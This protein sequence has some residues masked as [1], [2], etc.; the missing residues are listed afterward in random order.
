MIVTHHH[1]LVFTT[2]TCRTITEAIAPQDFVHQF[3]FSTSME[4]NNFLFLCKTA[5]HRGADEESSIDTGFIKLSSV[6]LMVE[7]PA[8]MTAKDLLCHK[9]DQYL[10]PVIL[11]PEVFNQITDF[12]RK[13]T[14]F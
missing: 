12:F 14:V 6:L 1:G 2:L 7:L 3:F 4:Q 13:V 11:K 8:R 5:T 10:V 9:I